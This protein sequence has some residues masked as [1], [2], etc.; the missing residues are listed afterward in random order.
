MQNSAGTLENTLVVSHKVKYTVTLQPSNPIPRYLL[1]KKENICPQKD[2]YSTAQSTF[3]YHSHWKQSKCPKTGEWLNQL[4][5]VYSNG[6]LLISKKE[7]TNN[8]DN[9]KCTM[10]SKITQ[11]ENTTHCMTPFI[12]H[13]RKS[14]S[15]ATENRSMYLPAAVLGERVT[16]KE[17]KGSFC[18]NGTFLYFCL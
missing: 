8:T 9:L 12:W 10:L 7:Q 4:W 2:S 17:H 13:C 18:S 6:I 3:I 11:T 14:K 15:I 5:Y 1:K 16:T